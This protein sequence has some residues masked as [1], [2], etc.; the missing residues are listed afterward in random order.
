[1]KTP[2]SDSTTPAASKPRRRDAAGLALSAVTLAVL[3][4]GVFVIRGVTERDADP[5]TSGAL[6]TAPGESFGPTPPLAPSE[7][8]IV[9]H[10]IADEPTPL[11][12]TRTDAP[13]QDRLGSATQNDFR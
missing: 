3:V 4:V 5:A 7:Q 12:P 6:S 11:P 8:P 10:P 1:M 2:D 13:G 9:V